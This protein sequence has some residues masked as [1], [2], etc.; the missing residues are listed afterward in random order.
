M[1]DAEKIE[2]LKQQIKDAHYAL[3][4]IYETLRKPLQYR[5]V[6]YDDSLYTPCQNACSRA[7]QMLRLLQ[8]LEVK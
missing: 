5:R 6:S 1:T 3:Y 8:E 7:Y 2:T 4:Q